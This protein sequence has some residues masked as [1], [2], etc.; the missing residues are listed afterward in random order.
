MATVTLGQARGAFDNTAP[1]S[2]EGVEPELRSKLLLLTYGSKQSPGVRYVRG[3][4]FL[5]LHDANGVG[6]TPGL[7]TEMELNRENAHKLADHFIRYA[8]GEGAM[9]VNNHSLDVSPNNV[10]IVRHAAAE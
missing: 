1:E 9:R 3:D 10:Q 6:Y 8:Y 5:R 4:R 7:T 2:L